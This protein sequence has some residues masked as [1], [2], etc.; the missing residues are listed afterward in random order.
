MQAKLKG[1]G[2]AT[3]DMSGKMLNGI[4]VIENLSKK[5]GQLTKAQQASVGESVAGVFQINIL[6]AAMSDLSQETSNYKRALDTA[7][8]ATNEAYTRNEQL[9]QTL[10]ALVNRTLG[11]LTQMGATIGEGAFGPAIKNVL[12]LVNSTIEYFTKAGGAMEGFG[13]GIGKTL[14]TGLGK[15]ISGPVLVFATAVFGKL[16][17][18]LGGFAKKALLD[19]VGLNNATKQRAALE[20][21][22]VKAIAKEPALLARVKTGTLDVLSVEKQILA[23]IQ[24]QQAM[25]TGLTAYGGPMAA[26]LYSRNV[27]VSGGGDPFVMGR[28]GPGRADGH[29]H[30]FAKGL[31]PSVER[32]S[33]R[34]AGYTPG[35]VKTMHQP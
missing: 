33:A 16:A 2:V 5:F 35:A 30:N 15:F 22:V 18:S 23:T 10:D 32:A 20:E 14:L 24:Q 21:M 1:F 12:G 27:R 31:I 13:Q 19:V 29:V 7:N 28:R 25:R 6:K 8:K 3:T 34:A 9:N 17:L 11:N 26:S 4:Q